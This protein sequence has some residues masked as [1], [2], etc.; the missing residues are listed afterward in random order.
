MKKVERAVGVTKAE[1]VVPRCVV[2]TAR[3]VRPAAP[4]AL[5]ARRPVA[6]PA[7][8]GSTE[9]AKA[10]AFSAV[11]VFWGSF[12]ETRNALGEQI[13]DWLR[14]HPELT[15][16]DCVVTQ[17]ADSGYHCLTITLFLAG[18]ASRYLAEVPTPRW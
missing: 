9:V 8:A 13:T 10:G 12:S 17:S 18:D 16:V 2:P 7:A 4:V 1:A 6:A 5:E 11:K 15:V 3:S 14:Q